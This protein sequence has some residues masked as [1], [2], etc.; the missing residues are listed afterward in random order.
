MME[1]FRFI[2]TGPV[3]AGKT[4]AIRSVSNLV[5]MDSD[6][7]VSDRATFSKPK[8][9]VAMDNGVL[10]LDKNRRVHLYGTPGQKRFS[11]MWDIL[12]RS[13]AKDCSGLVILI[14]N[15]R[16]Y[17]F[18]D[19]MYYLSEFRQLVDTKNIVIAVTHSD[20]QSVPT[21]RDYKNWLGRRDISAS[22]VQIDARKERDVLFI[23][24]ML[25]WREKACAKLTSASSV[26]GVTRGKEL[27]YP[28]KP[29]LQQS[30]PDYDYGGDIP[31]IHDAVYQLK[32]ASL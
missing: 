20:I 22:V 13:M 2:F 11:F 18:V 29:V 15:A 31:T 4:T 1:N 12:A 19:L 16:D 6:V 30:R 28:D 21:L 26:D 24:R 25:L 32:A 27:G 23:I 14:D 17:P 3:G 10:Q 9:T 5:Y 7:K 8:T